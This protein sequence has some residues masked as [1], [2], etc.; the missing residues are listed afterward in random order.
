MIQLERFIG[1]EV[2]LDALWSVQPHRR[3]FLANERNKRPAF[4]RAGCL[5]LSMIVYVRQNCKSNRG[6]WLLY[7]MLRWRGGIH[8]NKAV[9]RIW[10]LL[11][12]CGR[13]MIW[14]DHQAV[15]DHGQRNEWVLCFLLQKGEHF[16]CTLFL[17]ATS[18]VAAC[19]HLA[20]DA[21]AL[22]M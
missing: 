5:F 19:R 12:A 15:K 9:L 7:R 20:I 3:K 11:N 17:R 4:S 8:T 21:R 16:L 6:R 10:N 18:Q 14:S 1:H 13:H 2:R 22:I